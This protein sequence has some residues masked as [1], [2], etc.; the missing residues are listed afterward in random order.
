MNEGLPDS[1]IELNGLPS[2]PA[3]LYHGPA[4]PPQPSQS[5]PLTEPILST[6]QQRETLEN[7][8]VD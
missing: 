4:F 8:L 6:I 1:P 3:A 2:P 5:T 7:R